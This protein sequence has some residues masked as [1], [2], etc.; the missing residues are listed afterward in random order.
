MMAEKTELTDDQRAA[1]NLLVWAD[2]IS[3]SQVSANYE[4]RRVRRDWTEVHLIVRVPKGDCLEA[5]GRHEHLEKAAEMAIQN[6]EE[7]IR[8]RAST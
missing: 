5:F 8:E 2:A 3:S 7:A 6:M 4:V 1:L